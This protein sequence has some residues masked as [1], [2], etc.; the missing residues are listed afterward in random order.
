MIASSLV[1][2]SVL[3]GTLALPA[4]DVPKGAVPIFKRNNFK[5]ADGTVDHDLLRKNLARSLSKIQRGFN[6]FEKNTGSPHRLA[7]GAKKGLT[8]R[9]EEPL[10]DFEEDLWF[11]SISV[12]TPAKTFTV[13]FDTGSSDTFL[14]STS[15]DSTCDGHTLWDPAGSSTAVNTGAPFSLAFGDG[16]TVN[17]TVFTDTVTVA[18]L[19][20]TGQAVG[21]ST[22]FST[23]FESAEFPP[24][25]LAGLGFPALSVFGDNDLFS[26]L[27]AENQAAAQFGVKLADSGSEIFFG[28]VNNAL[29]TGSFANSPVVE[30]AFWEIALE[31]IGLNGELL[32]SGSVA[33]IVDTGTT[34]LIGDTED[35]L[36]VYENIPGAKDASSV[37]GDG[38]FTV[39]CDAVPTVSLTFAGTSFNISPETFNAGQLFEGGADCVGGLT[40]EDLGFWVI[41]DV[42]LRNVYTS[43]NKG[44]NE[45]GFATL[46]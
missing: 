9:A 27:V 10:T 40:G 41:G 20:A 4:V 44:A 28:G 1:L 11:G 38:F 16:S 5:R 30:D 39:P 7:N 31:G 17:G 18:G 35:V 23:G 32:A 14:P 13:D 6:A 24:D 8:K 2:L 29:F 45:V 33:S 15:C 34:L 25:G 21:A 36:F 22:T 37:L 46:A 3:A 43:F 12:G 19:T 42:F 26:T